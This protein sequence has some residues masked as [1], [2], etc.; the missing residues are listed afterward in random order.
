MLKV[1]LVDDEIFTI[2]MLQSVIHWEELGLEIIGYAQNGETAY[3][4]TV[5]EKPDIIISDICMPGMDGLAF[6]KKVRSYAPETKAILMS[7][8]ADFSYVKDGMKLGCSDYILKPI[9]E[10]ELEQA[11][12]K[13]IHAIHGEKEQKQVI[14]KS[15]RQLDHMNLYQYMRTGHGKN[16]IIKM[17]SDPGWHS[18]CVYLVQTN[19]STM[20][21]YTGSVSIGMGHEGY[22]ARVLEE[23]AAS[24]SEQYS[25]F[26][27]EENCW[28][29]LLA[30]GAGRKREEAAREILERMHTETGLQMN[31]CFSSAGHSLEELPGLYE[32]V[33]NLS[34]Y[35]FY[36][37][38]EEIL[39]Y[40]YNC[41]K[42][43]LNEIRE[44]GIL[45]ELRQAMKNG[46]KEAAVSILNEV[47]EVPSRH[48]P[49]A[50]ERI[51]GFCYQVVLEVKKQ[52][53]DYPALM[54]RYAGLLE[55][56]YEELA[57]LSSLKEL[58]TKLLS[59]LE[60]AFLIPDQQE[61]RVYSR[62]VAEC[63]QIIEQRYHENLSLEEICAEIAVSKNYFCYLFKRET[64]ISLWNYLTGVRL[65]HAKQL[66]EETE[67]KSYEIAF[68]V[69]YD[70]PSY[71]SKM[72]KKYENR[73]PNEYR[74]SRR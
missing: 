71:F 39:G 4:M 19:S 60:T 31:I 17:Q 46:N 15:A 49:D 24:L 29:M 40:G 3:E 28:I 14:S 58:K 23:A 67:L 20:D 73:T 25:V 27:Y 18:Y 70:N 10:T 66:L 36:I 8:Y 50:L 26:D 74:E 72:F 63:I 55:T 57:A 13:V 54:E 56:S 2:R 37:G 45:K 21:E 30:D 53:A 59:I 51:Y 42:R 47:L 32:E 5:R 43:E 7:A 1:L 38:E 62:P 44:L 61:E 16:K 11:L 41:D 68:R 35:S 52:L 33:R 48:Y 22:F 34:K 6:L 12:R 65:Q 9:D 64:G 69:G